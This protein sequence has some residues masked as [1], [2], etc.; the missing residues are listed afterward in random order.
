MNLTSVYKIGKCKNATK[1]GRGV[2]RDAFPTLLFWEGEPE[3]TA[4]DLLEEVSTQIGTSPKVP[5]RLTQSSRSLLC[6]L[7]HLRVDRHAK[8]S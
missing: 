5:F 8:W 7:Y 2:Q 3:D 6:I 4:H 1:A